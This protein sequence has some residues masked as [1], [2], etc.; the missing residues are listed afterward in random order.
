MIRVLTLSDHK[1]VLNLNCFI[2][3][4]VYV[5]NFQGGGQLK[6]VI[7]WKEASGLPHV[8]VTY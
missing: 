8:Q 1:L 7:Q 4:G 3:D 5:D 6:T 2:D